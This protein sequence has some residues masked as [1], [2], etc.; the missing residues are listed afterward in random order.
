[1]DANIPDA[2]RQAA[3][4]IKAGD[5]QAARPILVDF[6]QHNPDSEQGWLMMSVVLATPQQ[7]IE[8]LQ[9]VLRINPSNAK[10]RQQLE[11]LGGALPGPG[12]PGPAAFEPSPIPNPAPPST[13]EPSWLEQLRQQ[14]QAVPPQAP[15]PIPPL[16]PMP[17]PASQN[18]PASQ[19]KP[20]SQ[21]V[22]SI[23]A[24]AAQQPKPAEQPASQP[25]TTI[26][27]AAHLKKKSSRLKPFLYVGL[28]LIL[29]AGIG[30]AIVWGFNTFLVITPPPVT[31]ISLL[32]PSLTPTTQ[33]PYQLAPTWTPNP[34]PT[35]T[36]TPTITPTPVPSPTPTFPAPL[37]TTAALMDRIQQEVSDLR[38]LP[39]QAEVP[40]YVV[41]SMMVEK[42]L[43]GELVA[44]G[45]IP[46]LDDQA[47][48]LTVLG[49]IKPTYDIVRYTLNG[50]VDGIGGF[51]RHTT[52]DIYVLGMSF[53]GVEHYIYSHEFDHALVDQSYNL[54]MLL[55]PVICQ[56]NSDRCEAVRALVEGDA[57]LAMQQWWKQY[58][59]PQDYQDILHWR[60]PAQAL[61][62]QF[63]PDFALHSNNFPY[64]YGL[65]FVQSLYNKGNWARVNQAYLRPPEST[66]QIIHPEKYAAQQ[67]P[68]VVEDL[69]LLA[70][71]SAPW[72]E[73]A[74]DVLGEWTTYLVLA[75]GADKTAQQSTTTAKRAA[76]GWGGDHY[77]VY[78]N[79][80]T[81]RIVLAAHWVWDS[82]KDAKEFEPALSKY[83]DQR[84]RGATLAR[85]DGACWEVNLQTTC[86]Y[87]AGSETLWIIAPDQATLDQVRGLYLGLGQK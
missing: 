59:T 32:I 33:V 46:K 34:T 47:R 50:L 55:S 67:K 4:H 2:L 78:Y 20:A 70:V 27:K 7:Q 31:P 45:E 22:A 79:D 44:N 18:T 51:Y 76:E 56:N 39:I 9:R 84:F 40:R 77:Q 12:R 83:L 65:V 29:L 28:A 52:K 54:S 72:R 60:P 11:R 1:M 5:L 69:P 41:S 68:L 86:I 10:A 14:A 81:D 30:V 57:S 38:G 6:V 71:L 80:Q 66:E 3:A 15:I 16:P 61:P 87:S 25:K 73:I 85:T 24:A 35:I 58:A 17:P 37:P 48:A 82:A 62:E 63:P 21:P 74:S 43:Y 36:L 49:L 26:H 53:G 64:E 75:Y 13:P 19:V 8:C 42:M 23:L